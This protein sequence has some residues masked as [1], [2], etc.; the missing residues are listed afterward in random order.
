MDIDLQAAIDHLAALPHP[1]EPQDEAL[2]DVI[3]ELFGIE[4]ILMQWAFAALNGDRTRRAP[5]K[6]SF[7]AYDARLRSLV[8]DD[9]DL[10]SLA[11]ARDHLDAIEQM[12]R[13]TEARME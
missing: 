12:W 8:L 2:S 7:E 5:T 9:G 4:A 10:P 11:Q 3:F 1:D 13:A 6:Y